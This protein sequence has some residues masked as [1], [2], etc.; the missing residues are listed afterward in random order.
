MN[1]LV[2]KG[3]SPMAKYTPGRWEIRR[4]GT[5]LTI[6]GLG[7]DNP[8]LP[9]CICEIHQNPVIHWDEQAANARLIKSAPRLLEALGLAMG[10]IVE[11]SPNHEPNSVWFDQLVKAVKEAAGE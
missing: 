11:L 1:R 6:C 4:A 5:T 3:E 7:N 10:M 9:I 8:S 2:R